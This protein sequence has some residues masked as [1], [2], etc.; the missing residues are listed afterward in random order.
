MVAATR[1]FIDPQDDLEYSG[2]GLGGEL[3]LPRVA[4]GPRVERV[5]PHMGLCTPGHRERGWLV[6]IHPMDDIVQWDEADDTGAF[7]QNPWIRR[8]DDRR[9]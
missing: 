7:T 8:V 3:A 2:I 6:D 1:A 5:G 4:A 9:L